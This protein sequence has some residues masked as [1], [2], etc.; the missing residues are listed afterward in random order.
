MH[1]FMHSYG[2]KLQSSNYEEA[3]EILDGFREID[4]RAWEEQY[5][6]QSDEDWDEEYDE[7]GAWKYQYYEQEFW[8]E[9]YTSEDSVDQDECERE[10]SVWECE[11]E[12][13]AS[14]EYSEPEYSDQEDWGEEGHGYYSDESVDLY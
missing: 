14:E 5:G 8:E 11:D 6:Y 10:F 12:L 9:K 7:Q 4:Q 1:E 13:G 3:R 2:L